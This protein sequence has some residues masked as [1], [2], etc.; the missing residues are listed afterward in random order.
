MDNKPSYTVEELGIE[1]IQVNPHLYHVIFNEFREGDDPYQIAQSEHYLNQ[2]KT[3]FENHQLG[4]KVNFINDTT[5]I[6]GLGSLAAQAR[7]NYVEAY[8]MPDVG[9]VA[10]VGM[11]KWLKTMITVFTTFA[12][13]ASQTAFFD[14]PEEAIQWIESK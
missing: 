3:I 4:E 5:P 9:H 12:N 7:K 14:T 11:G 10:M 6:G 8:G 13:R 2:V 1:F